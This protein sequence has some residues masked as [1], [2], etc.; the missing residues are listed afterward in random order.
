MCPNTRNGTCVG[1]TIEAINGRK[2]FRFSGITVI[3][4]GSA[5]DGIFRII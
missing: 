4:Q 5:N 2:L 1:I 3:V